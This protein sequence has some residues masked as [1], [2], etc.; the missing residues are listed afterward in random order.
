MCNEPIHLHC[1]QI[2]ETEKMFSNVSNK[3]Q[4]TKEY[5]VTGSCNTILDLT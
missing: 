5:A 4:L 2:C 1:L 3:A